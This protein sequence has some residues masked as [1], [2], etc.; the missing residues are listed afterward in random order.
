MLYV[1]PY[2]M[3][4]SSAK[5]IALGI[6][7]LRITGD[8]WL[9]PGSTVINWGNS[10]ASPKSRGYLNVI[11]SPDQIVLSCN[12]LSTFQE[13]TMNGIITV[14]WTAH[15]SYAKQWLEQGATVM[16][17]TLTSASQGRGIV[18]TTAED[19]TLPSAGLYTKYIPKCH[20]YRVHVM[21]GSVLDVTKKRRR[22]GTDT[23]DYI[24]NSTTG[25]VFCRDGVVPPDKVTD[26]ALKTIAALSLDFGA[27]DV[28]YKE[29][30]D[31]AYVL[32]VN[33]APG[34]EGTTLNKY[35]ETFK[36]NL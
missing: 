1:L 35:I 6:G 26:A 16:A 18:V 19:D 3:A 31:M 34:L 30:D 15:P 9:K 14:P 12:K 2:N 32:E 29:L 27:V 11:N 10:E 20:E 4:S 23:N 25:W 36:E 8:K 7:A 21:F 5:D 13:L 22:S 17:R 24:R 33:S 28:L